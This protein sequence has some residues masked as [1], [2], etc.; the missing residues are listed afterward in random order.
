V[1]S[2]LCVASPIGARLPRRSTI[3]KL[4]PRCGARVRRIAASSLQH[5]D[6][7]TS[8]PRLSGIFGRDFAEL[9]AHLISVGAIH[10]RRRVFVELVGLEFRREEVALARE[11]HAIRDLGNSHY[12]LLDVDRH[13][14]IDRR[15]SD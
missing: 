15:C 9:G 4:R 10:R 5:A 7:K 6:E 1:G 14:R 2:N 3:R 11:G 8:A 13:D 12:E